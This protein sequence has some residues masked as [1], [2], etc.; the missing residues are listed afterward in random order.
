MG[1]D[2]DLL[3]LLAHYKIFL[4]DSLARACC[5]GTLD[6][7]CEY[8]EAMIQVRSHFHTLISAHMRKNLMMRVMTEAL[9]YSC[10]RDLYAR[11]FEM[12]YT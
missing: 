7:M 8:I 11:T 1:Q 5:M 3:D 2:L 10:P 4:N 9:A 12:Y 6:R